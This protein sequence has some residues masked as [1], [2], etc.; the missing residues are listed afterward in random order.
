[1]ATRTFLTA[2]RACPGEVLPANWTALL[3]DFCCASSK[4]HT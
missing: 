3:R 2:G 4:L 1:M